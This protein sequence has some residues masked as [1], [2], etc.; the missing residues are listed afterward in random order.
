L[1]PGVWQKRFFLLA[2]AACRYVGRVEKPSRKLEWLI[3]GLLI[4]T[5]VV[6]AVAYTLQQVRESARRAVAL[7][8]RLPLPDFALTNQHGQLVSLATLRGAVWIADIIFTRCAGPCP[9][10][11]QRLSDLQAQL[12]AGLPVKLVTLT[13][14]PE[15]DTPPVLSRYGERFRADFNR[16]LFLTGAKAEIVRLAVDGLKLVVI[17][18]KPEE[19]GDPADLFVHS[20]LFVV[21][22]KE[23]RLRG[24]FEGDD[25]ALH[26]KLIAAVKRLAR[27]Q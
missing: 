22:D 15:F 7:P 1:K 11:T 27:E 5:M 3:W 16:W 13:T 17:E 18:K 26:S 21:V 8:H 14:D 6:I 4:F 10:M 25:P 24:S 23:G 2:P 9:L 19:R 12:P 20:T